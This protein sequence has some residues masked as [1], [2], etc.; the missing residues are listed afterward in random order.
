MKSRERKALYTY[1]SRKIV[2]IGPT[3]FTCA[4]RK[5]KDGVERDPWLIMFQ[6]NLWTCC[7]PIFEQT[8]ECGHVGAVHKWIEAGEPSTYYPDKAIPRPTYPQDWVRYK[9]ARKIASTAIKPLLA[10][11]LRDCVNQVEAKKVGRKTKPLVHVLF[12]FVIRVLGKKSELESY[13]DVEDAFAEGHFRAKAPAGS[14]TTRRVRSAVAVAF[15]QRLITVSGLAARDHTD[16]R[17]SADGA[18]F[19]VPNRDD[20]DRD[21][22]HNQAPEVEKEPKRRRKAKIAIEDVVKQPPAFRKQRAIPATKTVKLHP[23]VHDKTKLIIAAIVTTG[24]AHDGKYLPVLLDMARAHHAIQELAAD[25]GYS[26]NEN[27][28]YCEDNNI[29][30][31][32]PPKDNYVAE[33]DGSALRRYAAKWRAA[34]SKLPEKYGFRNNAEGS[35]SALKRIQYEDLRS[36]SFMAQQAEVLA[37]VLLRNLRRL[38]YLYVA[39]G[40]DIP[41]LD[42]RCH[43]VLDPARKRLESLPTVDVSPRFHDPIG[44]VA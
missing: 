37:M 6:D 2:Q 30:A 24:K 19:N 5:R 31:L 21:L 34:G 18:E 1:L 7:C 13:G 9:L 25:K 17:V 12:S 43:K 3:L 23:L 14:T 20:K 36:R 26:S 38:V 35:H 40:V 28:Q 41:W 4:Q 44:K 10:T 29:L 16:G 15:L 8:Y 39:E 27:Y 42:A 11:L 22:P 33:E 32:I